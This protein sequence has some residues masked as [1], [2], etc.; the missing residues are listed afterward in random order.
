MA[1]AAPFD[2]SVSADDVRGI[3]ADAVIYGFPIVDNYRILHSYFVDRDGGEFKAAWNSLHNTST[4]YTPDDS[5]IQTPN[6]DTPYSQLGADLRAGPLVLHVPDVEPERYYSLQ[7]IDLYTHNFA[8]VGSRATGNGAGRFLL[9]GPTWD[10]AV[11]DGIDGVLR[12][13]TELAF[14]LYRTQLFHP[15]DIDGVRRVQA[16]YRVSTLAEYL[17]ETAISAPAID[18][19]A[20]LSPEDQRSSPSFFRIL[21]FALGFCPVHPSERALRD[22]F[23][24]V[25]IGP[26]LPFDVDALA[27]DQRQAVSDGMRD[28]WD[29][30]ADYK[31]NFVDTGKVSSADGFGT[32]AFLA[33]DYM[34][35]MSSAVL[36][37]Y[38]NSREEAFYPAYFVDSEGQALNGQ[39]GYRLTMAPGQL[40]PVNAFWSLTAYTLPQGLLFANPLQRYLINSAML[41]GLERDPDGGVTLYLQPDAPGRATDANW[42][43]V[44]RGP[45][46]A[47]MRLYWPKPDAFDGR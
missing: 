11:P 12:S 17:E 47:I 6:S 1:Q 45:F 38:G 23:A 36:G 9:A 20:P 21:N 8:Y 35:R 13:E 29:R 26:G 34:K 4:V 41:E 27:P 28:A 46:Y 43:P 39:Y 30:F 25:G 37:I 32:R 7:F 5:A 18:F 31:R 33:N 40:P 44:P 16:G 2:T 10:G 14:V 24:R 19:P 15:G 3:I 22:R 42:L